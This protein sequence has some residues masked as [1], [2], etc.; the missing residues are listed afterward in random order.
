MSTAVSARLPEKLAMDIDEITQE[1]EWA[2]SFHIQKA[3]GMYIKEYA[4]LQIAQD[5]LNDPADPVISLQEMRNK[6]EL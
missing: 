3:V 6:L 1:T 5:Q 4:D 2:R